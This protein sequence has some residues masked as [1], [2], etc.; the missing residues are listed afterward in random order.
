VSGCDVG[1]DLPECHVPGRAYVAACVHEHLPAGGP[2]EFCA[3]H[4]AMQWYC[5]PCN[6]T[7]GHHCPITLTEV[8]RA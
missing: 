4:A 6:D 3:E 1:L 8:A 7:D 2:V 5:K